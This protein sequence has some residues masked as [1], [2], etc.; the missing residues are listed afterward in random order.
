MQRNDYRRALIMLRSL[1]NGYSGHARIEIRTLM[2]NLSIRATVPPGAQSVR[3]ALVGRRSALYFA[4]PLGNLRR[5]MRGQAGLS[6]SFDPRDVGGRPL[7]AYSLLALVTINDGVCQLALVGNLNG[8]CENDWSR[9]RDVVCALYAPQPRPEEMPE[10]VPYSREI[11]EEPV[12]DEIPE[13]FEEAVPEE[14]AAEATDEGLVW[15]L[16]EP[17]EAVPETAAEVGPEVPEVFRQEGWTYTRTAL[18]AGCGYAYA[19]IG[20][21]ACGGEVCV[22]LPGNFDTEPPAGLDDYQWI[23][24][25]GAGW[26]VKCYDT[27]NVII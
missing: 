9:V 24:D 8:S 4:H 25:S 14:S 5:D 21:P 3:A 16:S 1:M 11:A 19:Y 6:V 18:P 26:W 20:I 2:G 27:A 7:E 22:A 13:V 17:E 10:A 12:V 23:G 15:D